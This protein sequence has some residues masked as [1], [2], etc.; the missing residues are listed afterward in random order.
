MTLCNCLA[1]RQASRRVTQLYDRVL[2]PTGL[3]VTQYSMLTEIERL[4]PISLIP[5]AEAM[6]MDR[7][8]LGHN[9]RPLQAQGY[10]SLSI[11]TDR[12]SR[13]VSLTPAGKAALKQARLLW[14][15]AQSVFEAEVGPQAAAELRDRLQDVA[16]RQF[17]EPV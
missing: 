1:L 11:G 3:R 16:A 7:A 10:L 6:V 9:I 17:L 13:E 4:A 8:T 2:A 14:H 5:L 15:K 12:R